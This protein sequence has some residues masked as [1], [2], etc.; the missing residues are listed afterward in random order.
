[1]QLAGLPIGARN[2]GESGTTE[3]L[4]VSWLG[5]PAIPDGVEVVV[6]A[7]SVGPSDVVSG[8]EGCG[9]E[10]VCASFTFTAEALPCSVGITWIDPS[11]N[12]SLSMNG[13]LRC[14][15]DQSACEMFASQTKTGRH[16][17][18]DTEREIPPKTAKPSSETSES[19]ETTAAETTGTSTPSG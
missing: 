7:V 10:P 15:G 8:S 16:E 12:G 17:T 5:N 6:T 1:M 3:C 19:S 18:L 9:E 4:S 13:R 14:G 11:R 2:T